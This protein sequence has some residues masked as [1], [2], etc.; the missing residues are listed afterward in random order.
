MKIKMRD[1]RLLV[2]VFGL[3]L[4]MGMAC[5]AKPAKGCCYNESIGIFD[6]NVLEEDCEVNWD[7]DSNC[8]LPGASLGCC[9]L[10]DDVVFQTLGQCE[11]DSLDLALGSEATIDWR[12]DLSEVDCI[13]MGKNQKKGACV[14]GEGNCKVKSEISCLEN[15]GE[16]YEEELCSSD[17]INGSCKM[18]QKTSCV[19][20]K[21][22]FIDSCGNI[23]NIYDSARIDDESYWNKVV[24]VEDSCGAGSG[25]GGSSSC[26]NCDLLK[27][28]IC[29]S[30]FEDDFSVDVGGYYCRDTSCEFDGERYENGES[31]CGYDGAIGNGDDIVGSRHWKYVCAQGKVEVEACSDGR[32]E[33]CIQVDSYELEGADV[34]FKTAECIVNN[35]AECISLN[36]DGAD[37]DECSDAT[38]C[39]LKHVGVDKFEF[40]ACVPTYP[41]G[42]DWKDED[43]EEDLDKLCSLAS[44]NCTMIFKKNWKLQWKCVQNCDCEEQTFTDQMHEFCR[45]LGDCGAYINVNGEFTDRGYDVD[46]APDLGEDWTSLYKSKIEPSGEVARPD[47][48]DIYGAGALMEVLQGKSEDELKQD[49][50]LDYDTSDWFSTTF[51][52]SSLTGIFSPMPTNPAYYTFIGLG[53]GEDV[54]MVLDPFGYYVFGGTKTEIVSFECKAWRPPKGGDACESC[55]EDPLKPCSEYRCHSLGSTCEIVNVGAENEICINGHEVDGSPIIITPWDEVASANL[56][57]EDVTEDGFVLVGL[58]GGCLDSNL[59]LEFGI[60]TS[61]PAECKFDIEMNELENMSYSFE[62]KPYAEQH[63]AVFELPNP[64]HG[65]GNIDGEEAWNGDASF[66]VKC[67]DLFGHETPS[68]YVIDMCVSEGDGPSGG[69]DISAPTVSLGDKKNNQFVSFN[70]TTYTATVIT[71]ELS[72]C[73]WD[74]EDVEYYRMENDMVCDDVLGARS[75]SFGYACN[76]NLDVGDEDLTYYVRCMDQPWLDDPACRDDGCGRNAN[77]QSTVITLRKPK[78]KISIERIKPDADFEVGTLMATVDLRIATI[79]GASEHKCSYSFSGY[80]K[81]LDIIGETGD[82][83]HSITLNIATGK[84]KIYVECQDETGDVDRD[85][86]N[87]EISRDSSSSA[88]ARIW[89]SSGSVNL[90]LSEEGECRFSVESCKFVWD[91][92]VLIGEG[93][94]L[95]F[96]AAMGEKYHIRCMDEFGN[97][98]NGCSVEM[99]A[100]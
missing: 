56:M 84:K 90:V 85:V 15:E 73:R 59:P 98:P 91:N 27:G 89:Q 81:M 1:F 80:D 8:N 2:L 46:G 22:R 34:D 54:S 67:S 31:W 23:A 92:G 44:Q 33:L 30:A 60:L 72:T 18:T 9:V 41:K 45:T 69:K 68:F 4:L 28:G 86:A 74:F 50:D 36:E 29:S 79:N 83:T 57:Y 58:D 49:N 70:A 14:I 32:S 100:V 51:I 19:D 48:Y 82:R 77:E 75:S 43:A 62:A 63:K 64:G 3:V 24:E 40:N 95:E 17:S 26:G 13:G 71:N 12:N 78:N 11:T 53:L 99:V 88:I 93:V 39:F 20:G 7:S 42:F 5:A 94:D 47:G 38:D 97:A 10:G 61:K 35:W 52:A 87:F 76:S 55:N 25:N 16:F 65:N 6:K 21:V 96:D 37:G 66:Y